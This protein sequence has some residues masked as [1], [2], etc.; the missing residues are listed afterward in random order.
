MTTLTALL[1]ANGYAA[2][3]AA[4]VASAQL[5]D[6]PAIAR[7]R[8]TAVAYNYYMQYLAIQLSRFNFELRQSEDLIIGKHGNE[9][10]DNQKLADIL[11]SLISDVLARF[12]AET[13]NWEHFYQYAFSNHEGITIR[14]EDM[15]KAM[16][17]SNS[18][19]YG[20]RADIYHHTF[21]GIE[22]GTL[23]MHHFMSRTLAARKVPVV[24]VNTFGIRVGTADVKRMRNV[25][26]RIT[27]MRDPQLRG[28]FQQNAHMNIKQKLMLVFK[29]L[30]HE[31]TDLHA[32]YHLNI[33]LVRDNFNPSMYG[34]EWQLLLREMQEGLQWIGTPYAK[35]HQMAPARVTAH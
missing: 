31:S 28:F 22:Y 15:V 35:P 24:G 12:N 8:V 2:N 23:T 18:L 29:E 1:V 9:P 20:V 5:G 19:H 32:V 30:L 7:E 34:D 6:T 13:L 21:S 27:T 26:S 10:L 4:A 16:L 14:G 33:Q 25:V 3:A 17:K 11:E